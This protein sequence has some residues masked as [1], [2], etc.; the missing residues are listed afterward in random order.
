MMRRIVAVEMVIAYV[1]MFGACIWFV[2]NRGLRGD[3]LLIVVQ[4][5]VPLLVLALVVCNIGTLYRMRYG[6]WQILLGLGAVGWVGGISALQQCAKQLRCGSPSNIF[7]VP[8]PR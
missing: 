6:Y 5:V 3:G 2:R 1:L 8:H 4:A 7:R